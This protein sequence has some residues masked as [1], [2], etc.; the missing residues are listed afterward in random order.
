MPSKK[1]LQALLLMSALSVPMARAEEA[2]SQAK[3]IDQIMVVVNDDVIT[4]H[5]LDARLGVVVAQL[6]KQGT[7]LPEITVL[8]KQILERMI[9]DL[10]QVQFAKE[11]GLR[12]DD[13][14]LDKAL[15]RIAQQNKLAS[16]AAF[17]AKL[18]QEGVNFNKFREEIRA[19]ILTVRLREREVD[20]KLV[21][22]DNEIDNYLVN[23]AK[24]SGK[25]E[26]LKLAHIMVV[27]PEQ[28]SAEK[29]QTFKTRAE[30]ALA[31]LRGGAPFAQVAAG[32]SDAN[33]ALKGGDLGWRPADRLPA[34]FAEAIQKLQPGEVTGI[35][36]SPN[37]FHILKL[38]E[39][40]S[41]DT[42]IVITQTHARHILIKTSELVPEN[43]AKARLAEIKQ[44]IDK[45]AD[46]AEQAKLYSEDG[47]APQGGDLGWL[48]PGET[49][50]EFE[51]PMDALKVGQISGLVQSGFG[52]HLIQVLER[53]NTDVS[54]EQKRQQ[55]RNSIRAFRS[56]EAYQDW[57]RQLRDRA[58]I[59]YRT[60]PN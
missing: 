10:L 46:F 42:P 54:V 53:R 39:R 37:G 45:G 12:V 33:D 2:V 23:Q 50:P 14:Q 8:E 48:S 58:F 32:Y 15:G 35:L 9:G 34:M 43:E 57:L 17:R 6:K 25:G 20:S 31:K 1:M 44:R 28:A 13:A 59:E 55:A 11:T 47:S 49:V 21:I 27:V 18:E 56:D 30:Q 36:R 26:E 7:P 40:R 38:L 5:E 52:W 3:P 22:S 51:G 41:K 29:I 16:L 19:E 24:Q 4:R 60:V